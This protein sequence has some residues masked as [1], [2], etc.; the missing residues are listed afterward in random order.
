MRKIQRIIAKLV[1]KGFLIRL[2]NN[3]Y[4]YWGILNHID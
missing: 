2:E 3:Q 1:D 4:A